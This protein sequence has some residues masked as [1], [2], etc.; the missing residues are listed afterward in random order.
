LGWPCLRSDNK[1]AFEFSKFG[2]KID[3][4]YLI[5]ALSEVSVHYI[6][7]IVKKI[8][9]DKLVA[10]NLQNIYEKVEN[11]TNPNFEKE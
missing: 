6:N 8:Q 3:Y 9:K 5:E 2:E 10:L 7:F 1:K 11:L 4:Q